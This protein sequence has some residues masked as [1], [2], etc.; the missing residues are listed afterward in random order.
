[1]TTKVVNLRKEPFDVYIGRFGRG[2]DGYFGNPYKVR[3]HGHDAISLYRTYFNHKL[4]ND[5]EFRR[6][7]DALK[8]KTLGCFCAPKACHG[9][10]I[11][12]YLEQERKTP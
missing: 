4:K 11:V 9:D 8:G 6:R 7:V 2:Q 12:E 5:A 1:M 10:V 3:D